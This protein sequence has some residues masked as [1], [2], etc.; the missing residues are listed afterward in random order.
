MT[1]IINYIIE[2]SPCIIILLYNNNV[3]LLLIIDLDFGFP[4]DFL[5]CCIKSQSV[6]QKQRIEY[7]N[8]RSSPKSSKFW[9]L[10]GEACRLDV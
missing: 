7:L 10:I 1:A 6:Q 9:I 3:I 4:T 8:P 5:L 2:T